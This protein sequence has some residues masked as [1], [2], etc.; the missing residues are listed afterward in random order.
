MNRTAFVWRQFFLSGV[1]CLFFLSPRCHGGETSPLPVSVDVCLDK[2]DAV[3]DPVESL[4]AGVDGHGKAD[5]EAVY[6]PKILQ[7]MLSAGLHPLTYRLRTELA[8]EAWHW[9]PKGRWSDPAEKRGYWTSDPDSKEPIQLCYGYRLPRRGDTLDE[10]NNNGYSRLDDGDLSTFWKSN[11]YLDE[12]FT[13]KPAG[14][15]PQWVAADFQKQVPLNA[16]RIHWAAP[17]A[18]RFEVEFS[19]RPEAYYYGATLA[20]VWQRFPN[21]TIVDGTGGQGFIKLADHPVQARYL[22]IRLLESSRTSLDPNSKDARDRL[23]YAIREL[24]AGYLDDQGRFHD[25][26]IHQPDRHQ[27]EVY[28]SSTDPWHR[29]S[30]LDPGVTQPG[31]DLVVHSGLTRG[32]PLM[33]PV[34]VLYDTPENAAAEISF[35]KARNYPVNRVELGEEPD[36]QKADPRDYAALYLQVA[37]RIRAINPTVALGGPSFVCIEG[38]ERERL[39]GYHRGLW[40][41]AFMDELKARNRQ[42]DFS[43]LSFEWYPFDYGNGAVPPQVA[44]AS[45]MLKNAV[46]LMHASGVPA[47]MPLLMSEYGYSAFACRPEVDLGGALLNTEIACQFLSLKGTAAFLY[48]YEPGKLQNDWGNSW[49]NNMIFLLNPQGGIRAPTATYHAAR[50]LTREWAAPQG[51]AHTLYPASVHFEKEGGPPLLAA[52]PVLRPDGRWALLLINKDPAKAFEVSLKFVKNGADVSTPFDTP[53][54]VFS[55]SSRQY[56]WQ[57]LGA[58]GFPVRSEPASREVIQPGANGSAVTIPPWS[59]TVLRSR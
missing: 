16:L 45:R 42:G 35:L 54:D 14:S 44:C 7:K 39:I 12:S 13:G 25:A 32:R 46:D 31:F 40:I 33:I 15:H 8:I 18:T 21:G 57:D 29:E 11:P 1:G 23:G 34:P 9:N 3:F 56:Q 2:P 43:F 48:G 51:G 36:G 28:A 5:T 38:D 30:D 27:T 20:G 6:S 53:F 26:V 10:A 55:F 47:D 19:N 17:F 4:G 41:R 58:K 22:R 52:Y 50:L 24:E 49:G 37:D 59:L